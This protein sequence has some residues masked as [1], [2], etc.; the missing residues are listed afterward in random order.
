MN[1]VDAEKIIESLRLGISPKEYLEYITVGEENIIKKIDSILRKK[2]PYAFLLK[3]N[4][5]SGKTHFINLINEI[6]I[7]NNF[8]TSLISLDSKN[9]KRFNRMDQIMGEVCRNIRI[10]KS[11]EQSIRYLFDRFSQRLKNNDINKEII[12][13]ISNGGYWNY[14]DF[15]NSKSFFIALRAWYFSFLNNH[16]NGIDDLIEDWLTKPYNYYNQRKF[17]YQNLVQNFSFWFKDI[18][19]EWKFYDAREGIFNFQIKDYSQSWELLNDL[20]ILSLICGYDGFII[21]VD[22]FEDVVQNLDNIRYQ[23]DAFLNLF[24]FFS[25][26][27]FYGICVFAVTPDFVDKCERL[28]IE[29]GVW[30]EY[31]L[32]F[33]TLETIELKTLT[34]EQLLELTKKIIY[35]H[36]IAYN[37]RTNDAHRRVIYQRCVQ[38]SKNPI[39]DRVRYTVKNVVNALDGFVINYG[40]A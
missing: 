8:V 3:G 10:P 13:K 6:S 17:L 12:M 7:K 18:R 11:K 22:E 24:K 32:K 1:R 38:S 15:F 14:S 20:Y 27:Y 33:R 9:N 25:G 30:N 21:L 19:P 29:K 2:E 26:K 40:K 16:K 35:I 5:G 39:G 28:L 34:L 37:W 36:E 31:Y 4:Y 23:Q